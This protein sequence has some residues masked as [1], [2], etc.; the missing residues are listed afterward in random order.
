MKITVITLFPEMI[1][2]FC[3]QS[4][5]KRA[6]DKG[7]VEMEIVNLRDFAVDSYGSVDD[8]P[9]GGGAG[10][11]LRADVVTRALSKILNFK[12][13]I[14]KKNKNKEAMKQWN[15]EKVVMT[16]ARGKVYSQNMAQ[17]YAKLEHLVI[18]AG[19]YE[20]FDERVHEMADEEVSIG[21][22]VLTGGELPA[23]VILD[24]VVRLLPGVLKKE[25][26]TV[27][28]S[29]FKISINQLIKMLGEDDVLMSLK[30]RGQTEVMLL[31]YPQYTRPET[32]EDKKV[33]AVLLSGNHA[34]IEKWKLQ[35]AYEYTKKNR[36]D[37][38]EKVMK[39]S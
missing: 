2:A 15:N 30:N 23:A 11:V 4:M 10:M 22:Y 9:Y 21:D 37:L 26:A 35:K 16:S 17:E 31:E 12:F 5:V 8:R 39:E 3:S 13:S 33:P 7:L 27:N 28:E 6:Q 38:L 29:F 1:Q 36:P 32:F 34:E 20:G 25:E 18:L 24:S 14:L 19:H